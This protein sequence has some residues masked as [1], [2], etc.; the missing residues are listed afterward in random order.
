LLI[1]GAEYLKGLRRREKGEDCVN[2][3]AK[4]GE[5][6]LLAGEK[7]EKL[8]DVLGMCLQ[9]VEGKELLSC[10]ARQELL[11]LIAGHLFC[12]GYLRHHRPV[13]RQ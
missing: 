13:F 2:V 8:L 1:R 12:G 11:V 9:I 4:F 10:Q 3:V 6:L 5:I 7:R